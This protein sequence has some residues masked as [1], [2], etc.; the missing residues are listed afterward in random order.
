MPDSHLLS[1]PRLLLRLLIGLN[2]SLPAST[3]PHH[4]LPSTP[5]AASVISRVT[6]AICSH[7]KKLHV[8]LS[9][10]GWGVR[11]ITDAP[12]WPSSLPED[13]WNSR[14]RLCPVLPLV[15][16][17]GPPRQN[18]HSELPPWV[19]SKYLGE[20]CHLVATQGHGSPPAPGAAGQLPSLRPELRISTLPSVCFT[21]RPLVN[22]SHSL[23]HMLLLSPYSP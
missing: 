21:P 17:W 23:L 22:G 3:S 10:R 4:H 6:E 12:K 1:S 19:D 14:I 16:F 11:G 8:S 9:L 18:S 7:L 15:L 20:C 2:Q 13:T 5:A